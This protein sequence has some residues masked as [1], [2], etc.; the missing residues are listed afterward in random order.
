MEIF[1]ALLA[2]FVEISPVTG[3]FPVQRPVT[4]SFDVSLVCAW[5][6]GWV[7]NHEAGDLKRHRAHYDVTV[8]IFHWIIFH[9]VNDI[10]QIWWIFAGSSKFSY[11]YCDEHDFFT[12][13]SIPQILTH[14][15]MKYVGFK[16]ALAIGYE[17]YD[18]SRNK[19]DVTE[20]V[21]ADTFFLYSTLCR[22]EQQ[23]IAAKCK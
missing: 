1:S 4:Q 17:K 8:I 23:I 7:N 15:N 3:Q 18:L 9:W 13:W 22:F 11:L 5:I 19:N 16:L 12:I 14:S 2:L 21:V 20:R 10:M 6:N